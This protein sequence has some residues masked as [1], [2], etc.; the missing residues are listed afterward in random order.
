MTMQDGL[1]CS[2]EYFKDISSPSLPALVKNNDKGKFLFAHFIVNVLIMLQKFFSYI[3]FV[4]TG[5]QIS[6]G[7]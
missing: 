2:N 1:L 7:K 3:F 4:F 5:N 6:F